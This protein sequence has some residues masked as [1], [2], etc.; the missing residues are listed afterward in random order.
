MKAISN[1]QLGSLLIAFLHES[2]T[3]HVEFDI[4]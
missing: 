1:E 3:Y 2:S 4:I